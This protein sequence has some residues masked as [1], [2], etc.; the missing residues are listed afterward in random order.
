VTSRQDS[1]A[2]ED[3]P[4]TESVDET[5][6]EALAAVIAEI[7]G[8]RD[9]LERLVRIEIDRARLRW[10]AR[11]LRVAWWSVLTVALATATVTAVVFL[12]SG[13]DAALAEVAGGRFWFGKMGSAALVLLGV[14]AGLVGIQLALRRAGLAQLKRG[15]EGGGADEAPRAESDDR[16]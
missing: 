14:A 9:H 15:Y 16:K 13:I 12:I 1:P 6:L 4:G 3:T 2:A 10:R 8:I 7:R 11:V 5:S